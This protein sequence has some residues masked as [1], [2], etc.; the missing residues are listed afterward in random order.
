MNVS[1]IAYCAANLVSLLFVC[2]EV[3]VGFAI[4]YKLL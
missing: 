3:T 4:R 1:Q 2:L